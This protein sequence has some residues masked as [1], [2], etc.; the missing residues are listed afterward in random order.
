MTQ[1]RS[2]LS[3]RV[4]RSKVVSVPV[5]STLRVPPSERLCGL[6]RRLCVQEIPT[7]FTAQHL[8]HLTGL[9][10]L[11]DSALLR[12]F[13]DIRL[14]PTLKHF[15]EWTEH[16]P[17]ALPQSLS[18]ITLFYSLKAPL[19]T[20][21]GAAKAY[22][23]S[24][25]PERLFYL[26]ISFSDSLVSPPNKAQ[27]VYGLLQCILAREYPRYVVVRLFHDA[28]SQAS[29]SLALQ[30]IAT[31]P[32]HDRERVEIWRDARQISSSG[33]DQLAIPDAVAGRTPFTAAESFWDAQWAEARRTQ[34]EV[35][36]GG[37]P[38]GRNRTT[39]GRGGR[40]R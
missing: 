6:V 5:D 36:D 31:L 25:L 3:M 12:P 34:A 16:W 39:R 24:R 40:R 20:R 37:Q 29:Y 26:A 30:T 17:L 7:G 13:L 38:G 1:G 21:L 8:R 10:T 19:E 27:V 35:N 32:D 15:C 22:I 28:A 9:H 14:V 2:D 33:N 11:Y 4:F 23:M 18:H